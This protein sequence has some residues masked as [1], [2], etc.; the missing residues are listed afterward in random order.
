MTPLERRAAMKAAVTLRQITMN[1]AAQ[2]LG[3]LYNHLTLVLLGDRQGSVRLKEA[4]A[5]FL[6]QSRDDVFPV[7]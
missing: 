4:I 6:G 1:Q 5:A 3:V 2:E 7:K